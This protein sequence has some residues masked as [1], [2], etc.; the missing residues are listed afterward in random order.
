M[1]NIAMNFLNELEGQK[2]E[3]CGI[4]ILPN[5]LL[6]TLLENLRL[7]DYALI[8]VMN[9]RR[10]VECRELF[11][12]MIASGV[13]IFINYDEQASMLN[14]ESEPFGM[15][16]LP[17]IFNRTRLKR[18]SFPVPTSNNHIR[19]LITPYSCAFSTMDIG[20]KHNY[21]TFQEPLYLIEDS[22]IVE[23]LKAL[24]FQ[25]PIVYG[26]YGAISYQTELGNR[27]VLDDGRNPQ[28]EVIKLAN[29]FINLYSGPGQSLTIVSSWF[30]DACYR[31]L[32][33]AAFEG[34]KINIVTLE[35]FSQSGKGGISELPF[36]LTKAFSLLLKNRLHP[37][38]KVHFAK[39]LHGK[40]MLSQGPLGRRSFTTTSNLTCWGV[41]AS[42]EEMAIST[43]SVQ[44]AESLYG[45]VLNYLS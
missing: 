4:S 25:G 20:G 22:E 39:S 11:E 19:L 30:P 27:L 7:D 3:N 12:S 6:F 31:N 41:L 44:T 37:N 16:D 23:Q 29:D 45:F 5:Q 34:T 21:K 40:F 13:K 24:F 10:S 36:S 42:S 32:L 14:G 18:P 15:D 8:Q 38:I 26:N 35:P 28:N 33:K 2:D 9:M 1:Y 43:R 17:V